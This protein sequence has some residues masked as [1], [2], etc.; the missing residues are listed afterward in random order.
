MP[1][2][3][4]VIEVIRLNVVEGDGVEEDPCRNVTYFYSLDGTP[5][6]RVDTW[7]EEEQKKSMS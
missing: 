7:W 3:A 1:P 2:D 4:S 6:A 5:L